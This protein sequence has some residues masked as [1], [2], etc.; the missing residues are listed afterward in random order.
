MGMDQDSGRHRLVAV[1]TF[2][3]HKPVKSFCKGSLQKPEAFIQDSSGLRMVWGCKKR[4]KMCKI[5]SI[6]VKIVTK[7]VKIRQNSF[8]FGQFLTPFS[9]VF[10]AKL[11]ILFYKFFCLGRKQGSGG[12]CD[13]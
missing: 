7:F 5:V 4:A 3:Q 9:M 1:H 13:G 10:E 11:T 8:N 12:L 2:S 6:F